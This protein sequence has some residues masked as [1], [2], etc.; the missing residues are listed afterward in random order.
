ML[1][2]C[3]ET[4]S[5]KQVVGRIAL[6]LS[7]R[8]VSGHPAGGHTGANG[9]ATANGAA[10]AVATRT[11]ATGNGNGNGHANGHGHPPFGHAWNGHKVERRGPYIARPDTA[12]DRKGTARYFRQDKVVTGWQVTSEQP[13]RLWL[14]NLVLYCKSELCQAIER[15]LMSVLGVDRYWTSAFWSTVQVNYDSRQLNRAQVIEILDAALV[16]AEHPKVLDKLD[17]HLPVCTAALPFSAYAQFVAPPLLPIAAA[18]FAYTSIPTFKAA[19]EVLVD[20]RRLA[21]IFHPPL[22][23]R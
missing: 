13:G 17:F 11:F 3:P 4:Y 19:K 9:H 23:G 10:Q 22:G 7:D 14:K 8:A 15:E 12:R 1:R 21:R 6:F 5:R 20:E 18:V 16:A 2:Y